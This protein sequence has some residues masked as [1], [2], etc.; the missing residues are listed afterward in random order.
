[1]QGLKSVILGWDG[2]AL[3]VQPSRVPHRNSKIIFVLGADQSLVKVNF[4]GKAKPMVGHNL[5][6]LVE[7]GLTH[8]KI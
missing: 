2:R 1:M 3:L 4:L 7:I 5:P 6:P 8:L